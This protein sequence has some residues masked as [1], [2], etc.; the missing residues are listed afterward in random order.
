MKIIIQAAGKYYNAKIFFLRNINYNSFVD[1]LIKCMETFKS[2]LAYALQ[3]F[4][5]ISS[6]VGCRI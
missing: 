4:N 6:F 5:V 1:E 3:Y 2:F